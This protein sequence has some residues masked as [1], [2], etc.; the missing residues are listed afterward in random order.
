VPFHYTVMAYQCN[1]NACP[2][3]LPFFSNPTFTFNN[4]PLGDV[5]HDN[6]RQLNA[7][8]QSVSRRSSTATCTTDDNIIGGDGPVTCD[9]AVNPF[10]SIADIILQLIRILLRIFG[11][12]A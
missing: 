5:Q 12:G 1:N 10:C 2:Q 9:P 11:G 7:A 8:A 3:E 4:L 6:V